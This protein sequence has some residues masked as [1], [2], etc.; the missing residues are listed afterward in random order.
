MT[1]YTR[2]DVEALTPVVLGRYH[3]LVMTNDVAGFERLMEL[4]RVSEEQRQE[5]RHEFTL[6]AERIL[7]RRWHGPK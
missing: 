4:Y 2:R 7:R 5:L 1:E 6:Y 3:D